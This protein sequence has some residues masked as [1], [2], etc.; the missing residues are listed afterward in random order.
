ML[1]FCQN[2]LFQII[3][4][5]RLVSSRN[6]VLYVCF[7]YLFLICVLAIFANYLTPHDP[8]LMN[9]ESRLEPPSF[10]HWMGTDNYGRDVSS[11]IILGSRVSLI[12]GIMVSTISSVAGGFFGLLAAMYHKL[13]NFIMRIFDGI[14]AFPTAPLALVLIAIFGT[15]IAQEIF[16]LSLIFMPRTAR[17]IRGVALSIKESAFVEA[18]VINGGSNLYIMFNHILRVGYGPLFVQAT[19]V[20][21]VSIILDA[22][23]SFLGL[24]VPPPA[25]TWGNMLGAGRNFIESAWWMITF[26]GLILVFTMISVN[27]VG[28]YLRDTLDPRSR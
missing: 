8:F 1:Q 17:I 3:S 6:V 26:P 9:I 25:P 21:A 10:Q 2:S 28:D 4:K 23:L 16:A 14:M 11:R 22:A 18:A 5:L 27:L 7:F 24:G 13:D 19:Y 20:M 15:G 12:I